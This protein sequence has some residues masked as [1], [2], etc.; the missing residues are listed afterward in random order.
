[1]R[2]IVDFLVRNEFSKVFRKKLFIG[3]C[4]KEDYS[5]SVGVQHVEGCTLMD[6]AF[7]MLFV[8]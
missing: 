6:P 2:R 1:M 7:V 4:H 8:F 5:I 3:T